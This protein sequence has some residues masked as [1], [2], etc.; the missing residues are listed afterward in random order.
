[1]MIV[2]CPREPQL[3][4]VRSLWKQRNNRR[5]APLLVIVLHNERATI[6]GASGIDPPVYPN[7]DRGQVERVC[8]EALDLPD[9]HA[10]LHYLRDALEA[11]KPET[12]LPGIRNDGFLATHELAH[13]ARLLN[14]WN[15]AQEKARPLLGRSGNTLLNSLGF[16]VEPCDQLTSILRAGPDGQR[17]ALAVLLHTTESPDINT[18][19]FSGLS[20]VSYAM[21]VAERENL[22][23][24]VVVQD[25][26][27]RIYPV[28][29]GVGVGRRGRH[30][31]FVQIDTGL[32]RDDDA[33]YL[34]LLCSAEAIAPD[35]T[36]QHLLNESHR[37]A[38]ELAKNI[39]DRIYGSVIPILA[40][41]IAKARGD[42]KPTAQ[43]LEDMYEMALTI[44]FRL[45]FIAYAEDKDLLPYRH[46]GLYQRRSLKQ[47]AIDLLELHKSGHDV[48]D[49]N[50]FDE[51][52]ARW[53]EVNL[54]FRA[55]EKGNSEWGVP[56]Y[57]GGLFTSKS[58]ESRIGGMLAEINLPDRVM[59]P[60]LRDLL[61]IQTDEGWGPVDFRSLSVR[62]FGTI[63]EGL[64]E[65]ELSVAETNLT[66]DERGR[67]QF[68]YRPCI[69]DEESKVTK[70]HIYIHN[71]SGARKASGSY[72]TKDFA[73]DYLLDQALEPALV[74]H[75]AR[76]DKLDDDEAA[77]RFFEFRVADIAMGSGHFLVAAVDRIERAFTQYLSKRRLSGVTHEL[78]T[79]RGAAKDA[80][81][82]LAD[83]I[84]IEDNQLLRRQIARRCI[85]GVDINQVAVDL[86]RLSI[87]IHTFV[88]GLPLS[89][90][91]HNLV[92]GNSLVGIGRISEIEAKARDDELPLFTLDVQ[93][94]VGEAIEPLRRLA[95]ITDATVADLKRARR[96]IA[97]AREKCEPA[98]ALCDIVTAA[99]MNDEHIPIDLGNWDKIKDKLPG[100]KHHKAAIKSL[101]DLDIL[102]FPIA[103]PE[104]FAN[105]YPG[106]DV[107]LGNPPW[108]EATLEEHAFWARHFP[109]LR[110]MNQN[111][112]EARKAE[113]RKQRPDL[114]EEYEKELLETEVIRNALTCGVY[115]GMGTGD[116]DLYKAF[117]W[118]FRVLT[119]DPGGWLGVVLPR[120]AWNAKGSTEFRLGMLRNTDPLSL[121]ALVNNSQWVF[122]DVHPQYSIVL[123][124]ARNKSPQGKNVHLKGPFR[125]LTSFIEGS[126]QASADFPA[127]QIES[128]TDS[129]SLPLL[130]TEESLPVF[131]QLRKAPPVGLNNQ[132][133]WR[134]R[135]YTELH[136]TNDK[137]Y[138]DVE[139]SECPD[140]FWPVFK[141]ATFDIWQP[142]TGIYYGW[143]D[144]EVVLPVLQQK[145]SRGHRNL[146][147]AFSEFDPK[148]INNPITL[149]CHSARIAFRD[150]TRATDSRT[151]RLAL[152]PPNVVITNQAPY[153]LWPRGDE[154]DQAYLLGVLAS[155]PLD[156]Y[157]RRFV[158]T[159]VNFFVFNPLPIPRPSR[160]DLLWQRTV[161]LAGRLACP[162]DR[163][164]EWAEAVGVECGPLPDDQKQDMIHELD[165]VVAHLYGLKKKHLVHIFET[166]HVGWDYQDRLRETLKHFD[167]WKEKV[168]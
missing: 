72:F 29:T 163:F 167:E 105:E 115:P 56:E 58:E 84:D 140:G 131:V 41:G 13:G 6:C 168:K 94:L 8:R 82:S 90:L 78:Q 107:I 138:M 143:A 75:L 149:P 111:E 4:T 54:I 81:G 62:E 61:I 74:D 1:M 52:T 152:V 46:N 130:P 134:A 87:W 31:T 89:L 106:F 14:E 114:V 77:K 11:V 17:L 101:A 118:R 39:R 47:K 142:D 135:P 127:E 64:L 76:L 158:E 117:C 40:E 102:H 26:K 60:V 153:L 69:G 30:E 86:A 28:K 43:D 148:W 79:L 164:A 70:T 112:Q 49:N 95:N 119:R 83:E 65:S 161:A 7:A 66:Y 36:L 24:V 109:G 5:A 92:R 18:D 50:S 154:K 88:P 156:W 126:V 45:L 59:G 99:R 38:G 44:L 159:H 116:P 128:W 137:K 16:N 162:D 113:L 124:T 80:L 120:S 108:E 129:A 85:Y 122:P 42:S 136:A 121:A 21:T 9:R 146:R 155:I 3:P 151:V 71:R 98:K 97:E 166:F 33:A 23:Y 2:R 165:A 25:R 67:N 27:L 37:F 160:G 12:P 48:F 55:V 19:R 139:S 68:V 32:I 123:T 145:R 147:S 91:D 93:R 96:A 150:V 110:S 125:S 57:D 15:S 51:T 157:A 53:D 144:S 133:S 100:S 35:G 73:V 63:Y 132:K 22:P 10:V 103:F 20:P 141:G 34:W 104:V